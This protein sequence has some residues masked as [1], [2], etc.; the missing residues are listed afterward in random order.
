[1]TSDA[2]CGAIGWMFLATST[3]RL[4]AYLRQIV[5][6][7]RRETGAKSV[8]ALT[9]GYFAVAHFSALHHAIHVLR[10]S[11]STWLSSGNLTVTLA[12]VAIIFWKRLRRRAGIAPSPFPATVIMPRLAVQPNAQSCR[13]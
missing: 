3:G 13:P 7:L 11:R 9:W 6:T 1:M 2:Y 8:S 12:L 10:D 4:L 5:A